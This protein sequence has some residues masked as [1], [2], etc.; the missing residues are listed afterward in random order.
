VLLKIGYEFSYEFEQ[1]TPM[2]AVLN[3]HPSRTQDLV[4]A[5]VM[6]SSPSVP[7]VQYQ[8]GLGNV[9]TRLV[10]PSGRFR[11]WA[12][13]LIRDGGQPDERDPNARQ[14][15]VQDLPVETLPFLLG[16]RYCETDLFAT[17]AWDLFGNTPPG[18]QRV[19]AICDFVHQR[20]LFG[21]GYSR[22]TK[23]AWEA[24]V[25][26]AGV[27]RDFTHLG[28]ALCRSMNIP[29]RYCT[30]Y[31]SD[32]GT[33][34][35]DEMDFSAWFEAYLDGRWHIF[36]PRNNQPRIG[37]VLIARGRDAADV[38]L[39]YTFG[40]STLTAFKVWTQEVDPDAPVRIGAR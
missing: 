20:L 12:D 18:W 31:L 35:T 7:A 25:E 37:R 5:D 24:Y 30:G 19:Q 14:I 6:M 3:V 39:T 28:I 15:A 40:R 21:Y 10:A 33:S 32:I 36:D 2:I 1:A 22:P 9:C 27:C 8:D 34:T 23:T 17:L 26:C 16:S 13:G 38:P 29:A 11:L 4:A